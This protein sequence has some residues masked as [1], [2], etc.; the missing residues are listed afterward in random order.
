MQRGAVL[1]TAKR[2]IAFYFLLTWFS[3]LF[4]T[5]AAFSSGAPIRLTAPVTDLSGKL[6]E[7]APEGLSGIIQELEADNGPKVKVLMITDPGAETLEVFAEKTLASQPDNLRPDALLVI[8]GNPSSARIAVS[9][10]SQKLLNSL[11]VR[12]II[13][14]SISYNLHDAYYYAAIENGIR[15]IEDTLR[16]KGDFV[17][18]RPSPGTTAK[19]SSK[20]GKDGLVEIPPYA[21]VTDLTGSLAPQDIEGLRTETGISGT[22]ERLTDSGADASKRKAGNH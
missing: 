13:R 12:R 8:S 22:E 16:G 14:E 15:D 17:P 21:P 10:K 9:E 3:V 20:T 7:G 2:I 19:Q 5:P 4:F 6:L 18:A 11:A 1:K